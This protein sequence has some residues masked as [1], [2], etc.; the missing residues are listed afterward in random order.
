ME[1][2]QPDVTGWMHNEPIFLWHIHAYIVNDRKR[3][4]DDSL[5]DQTHCIT[6]NE[7]NRLFYQ[8]LVKYS[9]VR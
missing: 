8:K 6:S 1:I 9:K 2:F 7:L 5:V 4:V 3:I